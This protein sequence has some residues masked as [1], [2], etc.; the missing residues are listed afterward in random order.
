[1]PAARPGFEDDRGIARAD[2][3]RRV[4]V[5]DECHAAPI[6]AWRGANALGVRLASELARFGF[7]GVGQFVRQFVRRQVRQRNEARPFAGTQYEDALLS[8]DDAAVFVRRVPVD[9]IKLFIHVVLPRGS[10]IAIATAIDAT[11]RQRTL[12]G[13]AAHHFSGHVPLTLIGCGWPGTEFAETAPQGKRRG[14]TTVGIACLIVCLWRSARDEIR[15]DGSTDCAIGLEAE[16]KCSSTMS[17]SWRR[18]SI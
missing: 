16:A 9:Q 3:A 1:M 7:D 2:F 14:F 17:R 10:A 5:G 18:S 12:S 6:E 8:V 15:L 11:G 4:H 13:A